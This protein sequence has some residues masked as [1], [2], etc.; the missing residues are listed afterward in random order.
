M[1]LPSGRQQL[2]LFERVRPFCA[3]GDAGSKTLPGRNRGTPGGAHESDEIPGGPIEHTIEV[4]R[5]AHGPGQR[6]GQQPCSGLDLVHQAEGTISRTVPLVDHRDDR[7]FALAAHF[8]Q[9]HRLLFEALARVDQHD[10]GIHGREHA[11]GVF[12]EVRV[13]WSVDQID[14]GI[15]VFELDRSGCHGDTASL[16]HRHPVRNRSTPTGFSVHRASSD[17]GAS[18]EEERF[19]ER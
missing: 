2:R 10:S 16:F 5:F 4:A 18:M 9:F 19:G 1:I 14:D 3:L 6:S 13:P 17:D 15:A 8:E 11:K 7:K 12:G